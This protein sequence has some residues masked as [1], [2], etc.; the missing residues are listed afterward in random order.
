MFHTR[1][2]CC[3]I[4][5]AGLCAG[6]PTPDSRAWIAVDPSPFK[7]VAAA[8]IAELAESNL[9]A[10]AALYAAEELRTYLCRVSGTLPDAGSFPIAL[11]GAPASRT[12]RFRLVR[13]DDPKQRQGLPRDLEKVADA[14]E[15]FALIPVKDRLYLAGHDRAGLLYAVYRF[16]ELQGIRWYAPGPDGEFVP[17]PHP[18]RIPASAVVEQPRFLTRGFW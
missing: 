10:K 18:L 8:R 15:S 14:A 12:P 1:F 16:L 17:S 13:L 4:V 9:D 3:G 5:A 6:S 7:S 11:A 2:V